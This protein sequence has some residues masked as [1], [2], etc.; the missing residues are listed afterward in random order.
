MASLFCAATMAKVRDTGKPE[1]DVGRAPRGGA[2]PRPLA[3][4]QGERAR[5]TTRS[6]A[7]RS[8]RRSRSSRRRPRRCIFPEWLV[9]EKPH[10]CT[11]KPTS[12][13]L[14]DVAWGFGHISRGMYDADGKPKN[15]SQ[16]ASIQLGTLME[17]R[18]RVEGRGNSRERH[19]QGLLRSASRALAARRRGARE[20]WS[21][22]SRAAATSR[23]PKSSSPPTWTQKT[24]GPT[25][26][27]PSRER[28]LRSP[29]ATFVYSIKEVSLLPRVGRRHT[30]RPCSL[31]CARPG[32]LLRRLRRA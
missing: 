25:S 4:L 6:S 13:A 29:R 22:A 2:Q 27:K 23:P 11:T 8:P 9:E 32:A 31:R 26:E 3:R 18:R 15:Y 12:R 20:D 14:R 16:L 19:G 10:H 24:P 5:R 1:R 30:T 17:A 21:S 7:A 28:W